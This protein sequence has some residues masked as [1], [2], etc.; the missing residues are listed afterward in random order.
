MERIEL[1][2]KHLSF[3]GRMEM[4]LLST[5]GPHHCVEDAKLEG[6]QS[7]DHDT[8]RSETLCAELEDPGL[9]GD[10]QHS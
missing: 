8:T 1:P 7:S 9:L 2:P 4:E 5:Q 3:G 6:S 10:V